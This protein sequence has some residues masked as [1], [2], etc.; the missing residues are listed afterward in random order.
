MI[1]LK[2]QIFM[3]GAADLVKFVNIN[4]IAKENILAIT[5]EAN[6]NYTIFYYADSESTEITKGVF[7]WGK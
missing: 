4:N 1:I 6:W 3:H 2:Q 5:E 7:G